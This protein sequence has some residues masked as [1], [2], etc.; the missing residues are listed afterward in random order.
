MYLV[1][2]ESGEKQEENLQVVLS[3]IKKSVC[4]GKQG[5]AAL[6]FHLDGSILC[7]VDTIADVIKQVEDSIQSLPGFKIGLSF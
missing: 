5:E 1:C 3:N 7:P 4:S 6:K 2:E